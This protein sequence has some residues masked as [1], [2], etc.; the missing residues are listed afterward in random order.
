MLLKHVNIF[1]SKVFLEIHFFAFQTYESYYIFAFNAHHL[2]NFG[3]KNYA[4][5]STAKD[6]NFLL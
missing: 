6:K 5:D 1:D 4:K 2:I 3:M